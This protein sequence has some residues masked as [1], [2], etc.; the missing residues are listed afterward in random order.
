[1]TFF[2]PV[3]SGNTSSIYNPSASSSGSFD[4]FGGLN[5]I[6]TVFGII[7]SL[8]VFG[9]LVKCC[10]F[11]CSSSSS[12]SP[13]HSVH[14]EPS[15]PTAQLVRVQPSHPA[16]HVVHVQEIVFSENDQFVVARRLSIHEI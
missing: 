2:N 4:S 10:G 15:P 12:S 7:A 6:G 9:C 8:A 13:R 16:T 3:H 1:M 11:C 14:V 5:T